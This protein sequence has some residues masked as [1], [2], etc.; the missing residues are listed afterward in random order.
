MAYYFKSCLHHERLE[1]WREEEKNAVKT[2]SDDPGACLDKLAVREQNQ[3]SI[4]DN[5]TESETR[6]AGG[7]SSAQTLR[8]NPPSA[9]TP[10]C[11]DV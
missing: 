9:Y 10:Y 2:V 3:I 4:N 5:E 11:L 7:G 1:L 6:Q 8:R